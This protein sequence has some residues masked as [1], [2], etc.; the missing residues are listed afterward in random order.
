M[1]GQGGRPVTRVGVR[2]RGRVQ[3][4]GF[5]QAVAHE[6]RALGLTGWV[7]NLSD[8]SVALEVQ[9]AAE[10]VERL[11][12]FARVGPPLA[13]VE[14]VDVRSLPVVAEVGFVVRRGA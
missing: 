13:H 11:I 1:P 12:A 5:R 6:A 3:G 10:A 9:G 4:V 14:E 2:I 8:G 7:E